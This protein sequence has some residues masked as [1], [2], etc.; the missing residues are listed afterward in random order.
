MTTDHHKTIVA[1]LEDAGRTLM[2]LPMPVR[3]MPTEPRSSWPD[4]AQRYWDVFGHAEQD[5]TEERREAQANLI[6]QV[7]VQASQ[8]AVDRLDEVLGWLWYIGTPRHR[9]ATVARMLTHPISERPVYS[10]GQIAKS[11]GADR[12]TV[13]RWYAAGVESIIE[14]LARG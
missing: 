12:R 10:W 6:N 11:M 9:R 13:R 2:M 5:D 8:A 7:R 4:Y 1:R 14:G 3:G